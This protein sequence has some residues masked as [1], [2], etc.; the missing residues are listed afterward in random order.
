MKK[1]FK[2]ILYSSYI[3]AFIGF[4]IIAIDWNNYH[5]LTKTQWIGFGIGMIGIVIAFISLNSIEK[6]EKQKNSCRN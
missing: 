1:F 4:V 6:Y 2:I 3:I 5:V